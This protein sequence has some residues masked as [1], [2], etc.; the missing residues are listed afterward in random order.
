LYGDERRQF[1]TLTVQKLNAFGHAA[2]WE[3]GAAESTDLDVPAEA[4][5]Q[6]F[7]DGRLGEGPVHDKEDGSQH[8]RRSHNS[9]AHQNPAPKV[10]LFIHFIE[11]PP[12]P[13]SSQFHHQLRRLTKVVAA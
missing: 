12:L 2:W 13:C 6:S 11:S 4:I 9:P 5:F 10:N 7:G 1:I 8:R 3:P